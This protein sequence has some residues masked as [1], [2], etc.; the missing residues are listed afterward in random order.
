MVG[1][2][3]SD[4]AKKAGVAP[5]TV[6]NVLNEKKFVS[7]EVQKR[8]IDA[9]KELNYIPNMLAT[10]MRTQ[11]TNLIGLFLASS[12]GGFA[13]IYN[14]IIEGVTLEA[15]KYDYNVILYYD[16]ENKTKLKKL[17]LNGRGPIDGAIMLTPT[18]KDFRIKELAESNIQ[19]VLI[20]KP[21]DKTANKSFVDVENDKITYDAVTK[22]IEK[23]FRNI[24]FFNSE[25]SLSVT[26]DRY[27]G[28]VQAHKEKN[29]LLD[30]SL[31]FNIKSEED[32]AELLCGECFEKGLDFDAV[33]TESDFTA[34]GVYECLRKRNLNIGRDIGVMALG[35]KTYA[36]MLEPNLS[37]V[38][39]DYVKLGGKAV[40]LLV[41][42]I[43]NKTDRMKAD[44][45]PAEMHYNDSF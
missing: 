6:S 23:G 30:K 13:D 40:Q 32:K 4:V 18:K 20:G 12:H 2:K 5:S 38:F 16:I 9:C 39:V 31:I 28:Y 24:L 21:F 45:I 26:N 22:M 37:T 25:K 8:V 33:L 11:R 34:K 10:S 29:I 27:E 1:S 35:G 36:N 3:I 44:F 43:E 17:L 7:D 14:S 19:M 15:T 42:N 41:E